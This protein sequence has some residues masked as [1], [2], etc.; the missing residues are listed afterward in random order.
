MI[1]MKKFQIEFIGIPKFKFSKEGSPVNEHF[2]E[3]V[4]AVN[5]SG[6]Y[7]C[8]RKNYV[9]SAFICGFAADEEDEIRI[10]IDVLS[11]ASGSALGNI[12]SEFQK[13]GLSLVTDRGKNIVL[14]IECSDVPHSGALAAFLS[15]VYELKEKFPNVTFEKKDN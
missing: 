2:I 3:E 8:I 6:A 10:E 9:V 4:Y 11:C 7:E 5:L 12:V 15:D 13:R 14:V 1:D